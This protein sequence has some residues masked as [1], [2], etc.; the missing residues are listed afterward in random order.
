MEGR[1]S[2]REAA[3]HFPA[4]DRREFLR[5][6]SAVGFC[7]WAGEGRAAE[8]HFD[9]IVVGAGLAGLTAALCLEQAG[10][11]V[12]VLEGGKRVGGRLYTLDDLPHRPE[13]GAVD[14]PAGHSRLR[15]WCDELDVSLVEAGA[16]EPLTFNLGGTNISPT[17]WPDSA[18]NPLAVNERHIPP[19]ELLDEIL[20][21]HNPVKEPEDW[22]APANRALDVPLKDFLASNGVSSEAL[23]LIEIGAD[24]GPL[25]STSALF[26]CH[27]DALRRKGQDKIERVSG[28]ATRLPEAMAARLK[29]SLHHERPVIQIIM[30]TDGARA[31]TVDRETY[32]A[33]KLVVTVP[34]SVLKYVVF[35]PELP[36][37]MQAAIQTVPYTHITHIHLG[38]NRA[39]WEEDGLPPSMWTNSPLEQVVALRDGKGEVTG[40]LCSVNGPSAMR[41]DEM[42]EPDVARHVVSELKRLRPASKGSVEFLRAHSWGKDPLARGA[43]AHA[44]PGQAGY[45]LPLLQMPVGHVHFAGEHT[46][47]HASGTEAA[48]RSGE[49]VAQ[50]ILS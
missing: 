30:G 8:R 46:E 6:L 18:E 31:M 32:S 33:D 29:G 1:H 23:R 41:L 45:F 27:R 3:A 24:A 44:A 21:A 26:W 42:S 13:T 47:S 20:R 48:I 28:G 17:D 4:T 9:V 12:V 34:F 2:D 35:L 49:R 10:A 43:Y 38:V 19:H 5:C 36:W 40:L 37:A 39:Y 50:Q 7:A 14:V 16:A 22:L 15:Y 25:D 11:S